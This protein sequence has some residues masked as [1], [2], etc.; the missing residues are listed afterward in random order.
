MPN[1]YRN[2]RWIG[3]P[4]GEFVNE[5]DGPTL[6]GLLFAIVPGHLRAE[7]GPTCVVI[8]HA[9]GRDDSTYFGELANRVR[10]SYLDH[11][12]DARPARRLATA[13]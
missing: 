10:D 7:F 3:G 11:L 6:G 2:Y 4:E 13:G 9:D 8:E 12:P 5:G 1:S